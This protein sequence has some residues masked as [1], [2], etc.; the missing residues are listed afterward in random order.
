MQPKFY[1]ITATDTDVGKTFFSSYWCIT[2][3]LDY[4]KPI[5]SGQPFD[6]DAVAKNFAQHAYTGK[7]Y[8]STYCFNTAVS[9]H[10]ASHLELKPNSIELQNLQ[11]PKLNSSNGLCIE[12]AGGI[13]VPINHAQNL[14]DVAGHLAQQI[15][16]QYKQSLQMIVICRSGLG[17]INHTLMTTE[18]LKQYIHKMNTHH[19]NPLLKIAFICMMGYQ[20]NSLYTIEQFTSLPVYHLPWLKPR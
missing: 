9:P 15:Y 1:F 5:Q 11:L 2:N 20:A 12:G 7:I 6:A 8:A 17:T 14:L 4:F 19:Q 3:G 16:Q 18:L 13:Y 10:L